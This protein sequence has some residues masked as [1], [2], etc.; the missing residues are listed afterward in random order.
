MQMGYKCK[1]C[2]R[3]ENMEYHDWKCPHCG[4]D[5]LQMKVCVSVNL[6]AELPE[7]EVRVINKLDDE[8]RKIALEEIGNIIKNLL[9]DEFSSEDIK[10]IDVSYE[11]IF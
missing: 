3:Y 8:Q 10:K 11:D 7:D 1:G 2:S 5:N 6:E 9:L 4:H